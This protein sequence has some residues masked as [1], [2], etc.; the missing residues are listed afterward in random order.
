MD[1]AKL[2]SKLALLLTFSVTLMPQ[3]A[4]ALD[5]YLPSISERVQPVIDNPQTSAIV[6]GKLNLPQQNYRYNK[7]FFINNPT[8]SLFG[9][10]DGFVAN[11]NGFSTPAIIKVELKDDCNQWPDTDLCA[12][13]ES[14]AR[15]I[16]ANPSIYFLDK[17]KNGYVLA[18][19]DCSM[20]SME[21]TPEDVKKIATCFINSGC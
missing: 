14:V 19:G 21:A 9:T 4:M 8:R 12:T 15:S 16:E 7:G 5:C 1:T 17:T 3:Y 11:A 20:N 13:N 6:R 18:S 10:I 2:T